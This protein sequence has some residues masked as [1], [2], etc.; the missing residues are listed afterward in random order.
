MRLAKI[1]CLWIVALF[2]SSQILL[3][4]PAFGQDPQPESAAAPQPIPTPEVADRADA[5]SRTLRQVR[6]RVAPAD[7][8]ET[9]ASGLDER[10]S[11]LATKHGE[12]IFLL[13]NQPM[14]AQLGELQREW[15]RQSDELTRLRRTLTG[16]AASLEIEMEQLGVMESAW[17]ATLKSVSEGSSPAEVLDAI[18][19]S[20]A[21]IKEVRDATSKRRGE[22]LALQNRVAQQELVVAEILDDVRTA[23]TGLRNRLFE[24]DAPPIWSGVIGDDTPTRENIAFAFSGSRGAIQVFLQERPARILTLGILFVLAWL[25]ALGLKNSVA[26]RRAAGGVI[27]D[28]S[29]VF[30]RPI[31]LASLVALLSIFWLFPL[32]PEALFDVVG[33]LLL[34]PMLRLLPSLMHRGFRPILY[35]VAVFYVLDRL[36]DLLQGAP[37]EGRVLFALEC[38]AAALF[39]ASLLRPARLTKIPDPE[40]FPRWP[41]R[42]VRVGFAV[43]AGA[44]AANVLGYLSLA[45]LLGEG[46]L[47]STYIAIGLFAGVR[48]VGVIL[49]VSTKTAW[50]HQ[51]HFLRARRAVAVGWIKR[52]ISVVAVGLWIYWSLGAFAIQDAVIGGVHEILTSPITI[53]TVSISLSDFFGFG[54]TITAAIVISQVVRFVLMEDLFPRIRT[55][56]GIPHAV[57]AT[58]HYVI[59]FTGFLLALGAA[60]IDL[61]RFTLLAGALGVGIGF[62]LQNVVNNFV[63]G[64]ILLY[65]RPVQVGDTIDLGDLMGKVKR[66]GIRSS[67]IRTYTGSEVIVPNADLIS[68]RVINW[69][70]SDEMRRIDVPIGVKYGTDPDKVTQILTSIAENDERVREDPPPAA[71]FRRHGESSLD[72]ELRVWISNFDDWFSVESELNTAINYALAEAG[73]EIPFPQRDLHLR[74]VDA[75]AA[76]QLT[77]EEDAK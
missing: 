42:A 21:G 48:V 12:S 38:A 37:R 25:V 15:T 1:C 22:V 50:A 11:V 17:V 65:E 66:I 44:F 56:R 72:F 73:V 19:R 51:I 58:A 13:E 41:G 43:F 64:I 30:R 71:L 34:I 9:I 77:R 28:S 60:G 10:A 70:L 31:A 7:E 24:P 35:G 16:R 27:E 8:I 54:L 52:A 4:F 47:T 46:L 36:R 32:A 18:D 20:I 45:K 26:A 39:C 23:R 76:R 74:S 3:G 55:S 49:A 14:L 59:L 2:A 61:S 29:R 63:S 69:T 6:T 53:G 68:Q 33:F 62:G 5:L 57:S 67:T 75:N 40:R